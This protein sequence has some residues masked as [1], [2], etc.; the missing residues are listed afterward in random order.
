MTSNDFTEEIRN[1]KK[2][3]IYVFGYN[4]ISLSVQQISQCTS[5][6]LELFHL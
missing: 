3:N 6:A 4:L 2:K 1:M 5:M